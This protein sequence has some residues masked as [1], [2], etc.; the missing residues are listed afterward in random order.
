MPEKQSSRLRIAIIGAGRIGSAFA[1][2]LVR[3]GGHEVTVVAR[4]GSGRLQILQR[5]QSIV[6]V[7]G[8]RACVTVCE[9]LDETAPYDLVIVTVLAHQ[10]DAILPALQR[11]AAKCIQ[12]MFNTFDPGHLETTVGGDRCAFGMPFVQSRFDSD[13]RLDVTIGA[14]GQKTLL[15]QSRWV[16]LFNSAGL[17]AAFEPDMTLWLRCHTPLC[18]AFESVSI[19]GV[20]RGKGASSD[21]AMTLARGVKASFGLI[22]ALGLEVYPSSKRWLDSTPTVVLAGMLWT[23][24]RVRSFRDVLATGEAEC[25]ALITD[26]S[27]FAQAA[28]PSVN[29]SRILAMR[30]S[31]LDRRTRLDHGASAVKTPPDAEQA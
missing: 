16:E 7:H 12:F 10:V 30:P 6:D 29:V 26:M 17:P 8:D 13:G 19:A 5:D 2:Q 9:T 31:H 23:L 28:A 27:R 3:A 4:S 18:V 20:R 1:F 11:S 24:S 21:E 14:G 15:S 25:E 22:R